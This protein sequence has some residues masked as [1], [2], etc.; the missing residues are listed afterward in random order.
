MVCSLHWSDLHQMLLSA[1]P[2]GIVRFSHTVTSR[3]QL[4]GSQ[5]VTVTAERHSSED[6]AKPEQLQM[7]CDLL[8]AADGSM[9]S[10]RA[11]LRPNESRRS[12]FT[13]CLQSVTE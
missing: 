11:L 5:K 6:G 8:V 3:K 2:Q 1:L 9:S 4:P 7:D 10:T 13:C 12:A